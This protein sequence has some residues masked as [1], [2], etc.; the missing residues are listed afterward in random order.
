MTNEEYIEALRKIIN[1]L[2]HQ[3]VQAGTITEIAKTQALLAQQQGELMKLVEKHNTAL[4]GN[5]KQG[6]VHL[7]DILM[8]DKKKQSNLWWDILKWAVILIA[9]ILLTLI[10]TH[11]ITP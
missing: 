2:P 4:Y 3:C 1:E 5:G 11:G 6:L 8:E 9:T 7:V 10:V